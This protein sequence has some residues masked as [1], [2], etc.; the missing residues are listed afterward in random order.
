MDHVVLVVDDLPGGVAFFQA[1]GLRVESEAAIEGDWVDAV[2]GM[3]GVQVDIAMLAAPDGSG[4][5]ELTRFRSPDAVDPGPQPPQVLGLRSVMFEVDDVDATVAVLAGHGG[6][7]VG[8]VAEYG[9]HYRL[10]YVR[11]PG[12]AI[13]ALAQKL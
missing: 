12:G 5:L 8:E 2:N 11:G 1:L 4:R 10:C 3:P 6:A 7:L 13:V 9:T